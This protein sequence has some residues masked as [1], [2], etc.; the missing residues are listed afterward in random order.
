LESEVISNL[1]YLISVRLPTKDFNDFKLQ[2]A[3]DKKEVIRE[4]NL[5]ITKINKRKLDIERFTTL[6]KTVINTLT[7]REDKKINDIIT[8]LDELEQSIPSTVKQEIELQLPD[9]INEIVQSDEYKDSIKWNTWA[10]M[11]V[12]WNPYNVS[13]LCYDDPSTWKTCRNLQWP[14]WRKWSSWTDWVDWSKWPSWTD[15]VDWINTIVN[16]QWSSWYVDIWSIRIQ[17]GRGLSDINWDV[18][19]TLPVAM[20]DANYSIF[21]NSWGANNQDYTLMYNSE[22]TTNFQV[23][24]NNFW[25]NWWV[26]FSWQIIW[27]K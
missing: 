21:L 24:T 20:P 3:S 22:A 12:Y 23:K 26:S 5:K 27:L 8:I 1:R 18:N 9:A 25:V 14:R 2:A 7:E 6:L 16:D 13:E 10:L 11:E 19:I 15:W 17:W 4:I